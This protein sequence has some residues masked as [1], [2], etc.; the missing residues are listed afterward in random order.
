MD[1]KK[2]VAIF[3]DGGC[4]GNPGPGGWGTLL[5]LRE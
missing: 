1:N 4:R 2:I 3:T 5:P